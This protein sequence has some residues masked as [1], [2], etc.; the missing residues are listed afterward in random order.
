M[1]CWLTD[2]QVH[3]FIKFGEN[4][5]KSLENLNLSNNIKITSNGWK[6]LFVFLAKFE[7]L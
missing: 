6:E 4:I 7:N 1:A 3:N 5:Q 2:L